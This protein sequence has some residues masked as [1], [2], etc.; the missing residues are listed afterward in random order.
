MATIFYE[1]DNVKHLFDYYVNEDM[2]P[3]IV[4]QLNNERSEEEI[5]DKVRYYWQSQD[6]AFPEFF[7]NI[8]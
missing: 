7:N 1:A 6:I 4:E 5:Q 3:F 2:A 8:A